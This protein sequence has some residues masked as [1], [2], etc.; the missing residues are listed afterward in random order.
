MMTSTEN[1]KG[2]TTVALPLRHEPKVQLGLGLSA[3]TMARLDRLRACTGLTRGD[4][5][6]AALTGQ[7]IRALERSCEEAGYLDRFQRLAVDAGMTW[8]E[9]ARDYAARWSR[10]TYPPALGELEKMLADAQ[11]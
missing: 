3:D 7:G 6:E 9:Y 5:I 1:V 4:V 2:V 10:K 11:A 8:Q